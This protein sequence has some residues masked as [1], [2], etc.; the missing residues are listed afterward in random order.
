MI[1]SV[2]TFRL[3]KIINNEASKIN[4]VIDCLLQFHIAREE[5]KFGFSME[6]INEMIGSEDFQHLKQVRI[7]GVMGMATFTSNTDQVRDEFKMLFKYFTELRTG[8]FSDQPS[9]NEISM[10]MSGDFRVAIEEGSTIIR[11]GSNIFG[12]RK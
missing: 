6:E 5:T 4:R 10:G 9:F 2:D 7:S 1:Q 12:E 3:L 8:Y 11:I